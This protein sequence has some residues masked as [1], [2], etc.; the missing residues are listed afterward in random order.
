MVEELAARHAHGQVELLED[1]VHAQVLPGGVVHPLHG[2]HLQRMVEPGQLKSRVRSLHRRC[3]WW[4]LA[5][6]AGEPVI[7]LTAGC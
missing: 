7:A 2:S 6:P 4:L 5:E 1:L 3:G